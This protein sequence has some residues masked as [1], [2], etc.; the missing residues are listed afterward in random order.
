MSV[1]WKQICLWAH[2]WGF[3]MTPSFLVCEVQHT[4]GTCEHTV[5]TER[6]VFSLLCSNIWEHWTQR[7]TVE[8]PQGKAEAR[9]RT[10]HRWD[11]KPVREKNK[12]DLGGNSGGDFQGWVNI[13]FFSLHSSVKDTGG[14]LPWGQTGCSVMWKSQTHCWGSSSLALLA[15][16]LTI[17]HL[18]G[19]LKPTMD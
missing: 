2:V 10:F 18:W 5:G 7:L 14:L 16:P 1:T 17:A 13:V 15:H 8:Y 6:R 3:Q 19:D 12:W 9:P 11:K 4:L